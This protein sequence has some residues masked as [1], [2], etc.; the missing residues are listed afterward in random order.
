MTIVAYLR[1]YSD[2]K[3]ETTFTVKLCSTDVCGQL[4][5]REYD[6]DSGSWMLNPGE[7]S[8]KALYPPEFDP[9]TID[10]PRTAV[11]LPIEL[12]PFIDLDREASFQRY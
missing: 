7:S 6:Y 8:A 12:E 5:G 11:I 9:N 1:D 10:T 4:I 2:Q 3:S